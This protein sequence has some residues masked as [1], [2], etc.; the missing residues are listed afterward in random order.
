M[1]RTI[2]RRLLLGAA[3]GAL[4]AAALARPA[5]AQAWPTRPV[6]FVVPFDPGGATDTITRLVA[7]RLSTTL[8]QSFLV[9]NR[10]GAASIVGTQMVARSPAD[11][12]TYVVGTAAFPGN[13][14]LRRDL[15]YDTLRDLAPV[16]MMA[17]APTFLMIHS[18]VPANTFAEFIAHAKAN[19][20]RITYASPGVGTF[21]HLA[22][23]MLALQAGLRMEHVPYRG[24]APA[25][26]DLV[27]GRVLCTI[28]DLIGTADHLRA[29]TIKVLAAAS[30]QRSQ[31]M[32][33]T[34]TMNEA[35][36]AGYDAESWFGL[37]APAGV[38]GEIGERLA[39]AVIAVLDE[40]ATRQRLA[41]LSTAPRPMRPAEFSAYVR[42]DIEKLT[43]VVRLANIRVE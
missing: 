18:S 31:L 43:E 12:Y 19:P 37:I 3:P 42:R 9:E 20:G 2:S 5:L 15:P 28:S 32:P 23:E 13:A 34:P 30:A 41:D 10:S 24:S 35:G 33:N 40:P 22:A 8:G 7:A 11:G 21:P 39:D 27:A 36:L 6:R 26:T 17:T 16:V 1:T 14:A 29:G 4:A 38:P 25:L